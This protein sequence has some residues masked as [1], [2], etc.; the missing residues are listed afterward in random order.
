MLLMSARVSPCSAR[1]KRSS[2]GRLTR[3]CLPSDSTFMLGWKVNSSLP[4]GPSTF[5][6]PLARA[7]FTPEGMAIGCLPIRDIVNLPC[8]QVGVRWIERFVSFISTASTNHQLPTTNYQLLP[9]RAQNLTADLGLL[10][11]AVGHHTSAGGQDGY[12]QSIQHLFDFF[13]SLVNSPP[14]LG[15]PFDVADHLLAVRAILEVHL[16]YDVGLAEVARDLEF[17]LILVFGILDVFA[18]LVA[19]NEPLLEEDFG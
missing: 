9:Y 6:M 7:T 3:I 13:V 16:E 2:S 18:G 5:T 12:T 8:S 4:F 14:G 1:F 10:G 19:E 17:F 15:I 11:L